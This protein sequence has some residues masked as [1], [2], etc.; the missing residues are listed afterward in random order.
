MLAWVPSPF[1]KPTDIQ[2]VRTKILVTYPLPKQD[3]VHILVDSTKEFPHGSYS[4]KSM[5]HGFIDCVYSGP[6][7]V[8]RVRSTQSYDRDRDVIHTQITTD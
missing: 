5:P 2:G 1:G 3:Q 6:N 7:R 4:A 8:C